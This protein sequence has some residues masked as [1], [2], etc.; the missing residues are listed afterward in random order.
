MLAGHCAPLRRFALLCTTATAAA[1]VT[2]GAALGQPAGGTQAQAEE[3]FGIDEIV[4]TGSRIARAGYDTLQPAVNLDSE[5]IDSRGFAN[6]ADALNEVPAFGLGVSNTGG[7]E[8]QSTGQ[9]F[10]DAFGLG[11]QRTLP[12]INGRRVVGQNTPGLGSIASAGLQVD[13]N[14]IPTALVERVETVFVGGAPIYGTDAIAGTVNIILKDDFEGFSMDAQ[15]GV[16]QRGDAQNGRIRGVWGANTSDGRGNVTIAAEYSTIRELQSKDNAIARRQD[17]FCENPEAG[18]DALGFPIVNPNDGLPDLV[19]CQDAGNIW[20]V[21]NS[22]MPLLPDAFLAFGNGAGALRDA[23]GNPLVFDAG[24]NLITWEQANLG[25]PRAIFFSRGADGFNNPLVFPLD[26]RNPLINPLDRW[27]LMGNGHYEVADNTRLFLEGMFSRSEADGS[28]RDV[29]PFSTNV[30]APGSEGAIRVNINDN[31]FVTQQTRDILELNGVYDPTSEEDQFFQ[32]TRSNID[33]VDGNRDFREQNVFRF[34]VGLEGDMEFLGRGWRW[35]TAFNFG[36][37]NATVRQPE[38]NGPR[39]ALALDAVTDPETGQIVCRAQI[40]P[41]ESVFDNVFQ[42]PALSDIDECIPFNPIGLQDVSEEQRAFLIQDDFQSTKIRQLTYEGNVTGEVF[43]LPAGPVSVA[44]GFIHRREQARFNVD[45]A[46]AIGIDPAVAVRNVTGK[47]NTTELYSETVLPIIENGTGPGFDVP[48]IASLQLEGA[49]RFVD[50]SRSGN[51]VTWTV[52][53]RLRPA[54]PL[55]EDGL[56]I[57]GNFTQ[58][59]RAPSVQELFLPRSQIDTFAQD[60][61]DP[62]F[63]TAGSNPDIRRAN[64]EA[65]VANLKQQGVLEQDFDLSDFT[66]LINNRTEPGFTGGNQD[67]DNEVADSWTVGAVFAPPALPGFTLSVDWTSISIGNEIASLSA[68]D[69]LV[70]C[71]DSPNFPNVEA[72]DRFRRDSEFQVRTPETGFLNAAR[73]DFAGL[74]SNAEYRFDAGDLIDTMPGAFRITAQFFHVAKHEREV[75]GGDLNILDGELGQEKFRYQ[76]NLNYDVDRL[77][78]LWQ[79]RSVGSFFIDRQAGEERFEFPKVPNQRIYNTTIS[80]QLTDRFRLRGVVNN[81]FDKR[82]G[83][84]RAAASQGNDFIFRDVVGR[85]FLFGVSAN[86]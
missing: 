66:S 82:D 23:Q 40:D 42:R 63:I 65:Q 34:V 37:T 83:P 31:P 78:L 1:A 4:V 61:C 74:I 44:G 77:S 80:Y 20:Q 6:V 50:N 57:R 25:T 36:E 41:P 67:L 13:L 15:Y 48:G 70:A 43:D 86:F 75:A 76:L 28:P 8:P 21:P 24:G 52:G 58:S 14:I 3:D 38:I 33:I 53:G 19:L 73:R 22:G 54:L 79:V 7:Q 30:F 18:V 26:Q 64:C 62:D 51:D 10:V 39:F 12:L 45:R 47:F 46:T 71:F 56:T 2:S 29:P 16:D 17:D 84:V 27:I 32:V 49:L 69:I 60:P 35:D 9:N 55:I 81:V 59:I 68:T 72:C 5:F 11:T 85:R